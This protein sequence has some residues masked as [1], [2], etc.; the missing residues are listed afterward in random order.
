[1]PNDL[2]PLAERIAQVV[3]AWND[4]A[5]YDGCPTRH[6]SEGPMCSHEVQALAADL[7][8]ELASGTTEA[9]V[10]AEAKS[11]E[12]YFGITDATYYITSR[13]VKREALALANHL[14]ANRIAVQDAQVKAL[15][16]ALAAIAKDEPDNLHGRH[17]YTHRKIA[18][19]ALRPRRPHEPPA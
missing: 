2:S 8:Q 12:A 9:Q 16:E 7:A 5:E 6:S 13:N 3:A 11:I 14:V 18:R 10:E 19:A 4:R 15:R 17:C 1:M